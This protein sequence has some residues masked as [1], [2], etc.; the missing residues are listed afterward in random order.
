MK[1]SRVKKIV[2]AVLENSE[3]ARKD[4]FV[5]VKKV[6]QEMGIPSSITFENLTNKHLELKLPS[7]ESICRARRTIIKDYPELKSNVEIRKIE[8]EK[9]V[10]YAREN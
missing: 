5:L 10:E 9:Y 6:Y 4:N 8:E 7:F 2:Q 3:E 1:L